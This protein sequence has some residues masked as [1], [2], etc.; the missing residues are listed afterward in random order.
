MM[1]ARTYEAWTQHLGLKR[2]SQLEN[3]SFDFGVVEL[4]AVSGFGLRVWRF[5]GCAFE[6]LEVWG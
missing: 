3:F 4:G 6:G 5:K 1:A 2:A